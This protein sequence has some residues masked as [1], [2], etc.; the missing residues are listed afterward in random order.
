MSISKLSASLYALGALLGANAFPSS[1]G[2]TYALKERHAVPRAWSAVGPASKSETINLQIGLKQRNEGIVERHLIEV[3]NPTHERYGLHLTAAEIHE[4]VSPSDETIDL[5]H[6]WLREH[7]ISRSAMSPSKDWI[8]IVVPIE[9]AEELLQTS[10]STFRHHDGSTVSRAPEWFLPA[11][12]HEHIDVVQPTTSFFKPAPNAK[13]WGPE[14]KG[15]PHSMSWWEH[16]GKHMYGGHGHGHNSVT[17]HTAAVAAA[18]NVSF[19]TPTCLR[20]LY[21]TLD[22]TPKVP[23]KNKIGINNYLNETNKR[24]DISLFLETFRPEAAAAAYNFT[25]VTI[26]DAPNDQGS[27]VAEIAADV[28]VEGNLDAELVLSISYPTPLTAFST[29]GSPPFLPDLNTPTD[30]NEPYLTWLTYALAQDDLPQVLSTSYGDD[31]QSVPYSYAKRACAGYAQ[32]GARGISVL[33]SSGDAGVGSNGTCFSNDNSSTPMFIPNFPASC[34]WVTTVGGTAGFNPEVAVSRFG[35]GAGFSN[36]FGA[37]AYQ[38]ATVDAYIASLGDLY[39]GLYNKSGR[40][41]PDVAAQGNHDAIVWGGNITTVGGTSASSPTFA[42]VITLVNDA[43][44]AAG[45]KPLGFL[46]PWI[47]GGAYKALTDITSGSSIGCNTSGFPAQ[48]GWDAVTGFGT[49]VF[50]K[51]VAAAF[52]K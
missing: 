43:L 9:K 7:G 30:T 20:T 36:Y 52:E 33:F 5:V 6:D 31:E 25:I 11:H 24:S 16:T 45:R 32:L 28:N 22:Y 46:N 35:S 15:K 38:V 29:G 1:L 3:S 48:A 18:C 8:S 4:M 13:E 12:L 17:N 27:D 2:S 23:G 26:A 51:L 44:L 19:T 39:E 14:L 40:G 10:Y 50:D 41:Y 37:P 47:Y 34:P 49:P 21:G 42:A